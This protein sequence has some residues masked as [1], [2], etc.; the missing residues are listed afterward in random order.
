MADEPPLISDPDM[1]E[2][3]DGQTHY[4]GDGCNPPHLVEPPRCPR[5]DRPMIPTTER[6]ASWACRPCVLLLV[7]MSAVPSYDPVMSTT[8]EPTPT[9]PVEPDDPADPELPEQPE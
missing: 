8:P 4:V 2:G 5:C 6:A 3:D 7:P 9:Q 1:R